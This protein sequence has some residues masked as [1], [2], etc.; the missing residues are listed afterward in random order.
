MER[1]IHRSDTGVNTVE[2]NVAG[3][4][5]GRLTKQR[6][7]EK[8]A[9][10]KRKKQIQEDAHRA[11]SNIDSRF[12]ASSLAFSTRVVG[13]MSKEEYV[14]RS[15]ELVSA[16]RDEA[17]L[18]ALEAPTGAE[19]AQRKKAKKDK[20]AKKRAL[21][22]LSFQAGDNDELSAS[23]AAAT[24][25]AP[26]TAFSPSSAPYLHD[27]EFAARVA[28]KRLKNPN[29]STRFLPD[30]EREAA[31]AALRAKLEEQWHAEQDRL[32]A[33][34]LEVTYSYWDGS[35]HRRTMT[36]AK[37]TSVGKFLEQV[38]CELV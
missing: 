13:L 2:G 32:K 31:A 19:A 18:G 25:D 29:V 37:G 14:S 24:A 30:K 33:E 5:A 20:A 21:A 6:D 8:A 11:A 28:K 38:C 34:K 26:T 1:D 12:N 16:S 3:A 17:T 7:E 23:C 15:A 4:R 9:Y 35:G 36:C 10:E 22:A 27:T